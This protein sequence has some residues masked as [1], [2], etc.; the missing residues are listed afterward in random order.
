MQPDPE[1]QERPDGIRGSRAEPS[2]IV[3]S[4]PLSAG[5]GG[6]RRPRDG[7]ESNPAS[8]RERGRPARSGSSARIYRARRKWLRKRGPASWLANLRSVRRPQ[9]VSPQ[10]AKGPPARAHSEPENDVGRA[11]EADVARENVNGTPAEG[12]P[13]VQMSTGRPADETCTAIMPTGPPARRHSPK[14]TRSGR[15]ANDISRAKRAWAG[16]PIDIFTLQL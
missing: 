9:G 12:F 2:R 15:P 4:T 8:Y 14:K 3:F 1:R 5:A 10:N 16:R 11:A 6:S 13:E 7:K